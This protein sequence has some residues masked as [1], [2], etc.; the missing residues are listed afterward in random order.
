MRRRLAVPAGP[1]HADSMR[2][3]QE[4]CGFGPHPGAK[5]G[6]RWEPGG[7]AVCRSE[8]ST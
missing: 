6:F 3:M 7:G 8:A 1:W 5:P 2:I 4:R